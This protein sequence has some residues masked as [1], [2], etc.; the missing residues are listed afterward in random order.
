MCGADG[1]TGIQRAEDRRTDRP[2]TDPASARRLIVDGL[3]VVAVDADFTVTGD[4]VKIDDTGKFKDAADFYK[5]YVVEQ[6]TALVPAT[7]AFA[8]AVKKGD[9]AGAKGLYPKAR[10]YYE[11]IEP[12]AESFPDDLDPRIDLREADLEPGQKWTGFHALE[13]QL[14]V[15]GLQ[16]DANALADQLLAD[17]KELDAGVKA[18]DWKIDSTQ[19]ASGAQTLLDEIAKTKITGEEEAYS[20]IDLLDFEANVEG[21]LQ[22]FAT[23]KPALDQIDIERRI[24]GVIAL[25]PPHADTDGRIATELGRRFGDSLIGIVEQSGSF[26]RAA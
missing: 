14:W 21:S 1:A 22:A 16:P 11:R 2:E 24:D 26:G 23:L 12:V 13:K 6:T 7:E 19:I 10:T 15:T 5:K 20:K 25:V 3:D 8:A 9:V 4:T 18:P 17:V